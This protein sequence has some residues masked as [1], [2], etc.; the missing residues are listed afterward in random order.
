MRSTSDL[1]SSSASLN[2]SSDY[3]R[4][5]VINFFKE[6]FCSANI[7][8]MHYLKIIIFYY[9]SYNIMKG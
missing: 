5:E 9:F 7:R 3:E 4:L 1:S 2:K 8:T 6:T